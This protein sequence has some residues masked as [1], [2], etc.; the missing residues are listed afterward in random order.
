[1]GRVGRPG[2]LT[3]PLGTYPSVYLSLPPHGGEGVCWA[4]WAPGGVLGPLGVII[5]HALTLLG[6]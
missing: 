3:G 4:P 1:M 5:Y 2:A 6:P